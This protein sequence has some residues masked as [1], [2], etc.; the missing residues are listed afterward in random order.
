MIGMKK[1]FLT[2]V[3]V[4]L[5]VGCAWGSICVSPEGD[6]AGD[7]SAQRPFRTLA[8]A[9]AAA[10]KA[11]GGEIRLADGTYEL[12]RPLELT[13]ADAGLVFTAAPGA[14][15][16]V[17]AGRR[18]RNWTV[19]GKG[20]WHAKFPAGAKFS[21]FYVNGQRRTRPFL[22]RKGY[23]FVKAEAAASADGLQQF[24]AREGAFDPAWTDIADIEACVVH[25]WSMS[26][27]PVK[28]YDPKSG[29]VTLAHPFMSTT[30]FTKMA[31]S[32]WYRLDNVRA[33]FGEPGD[34]YLGR[35]GDLAYAP[36]PGEDPLQTECVASCLPCAVKAVGAT[37]VVFRGLVFA[38]ADWTVPAKGHYYAQAAGDLPGAVDV[39]HSRGIRLERCAVLHTGAYA[40]SFGKGAHDC[41]A[42]DCELVDL[43]AGGVKIGCVWEGQNDVRNHGSGCVVENCLIRGGGRV[44]PAGVGVFIAH[45][46]HCR[47][48][49][50]TIHDLYYSGVSLGWNWGY[51][52]TAHDNIIEWNR[53][54]DIGQTVLSDMGGIYALGRQRGSVERFNHISDVRHSRYGAF[55]I[56]FDSGSSL[57]TVTNNVVHDCDG[58]NW[59]LQN[60]SASNVVENNI[61]ACAP[62][63]QLIVSRPL[64][65]ARPTRFARNLVYWEEG[66]FGTAGAGT[67]IVDSASNLYWTAPGASEPK[68]LCGFTKKDPCFVDPAK[69]DFRLH[70]EAAAR[71]VGFVPFSVAESGRRGAA[72]FTA[73][74][75]PVTKVFF[76]APEPPEEP[77]REDFENVAAAATSPCPGWQ[78]VP[79]TSTN[80]F[81]LVEGGAAQGR[82]WLE[83]TD[84]FP[85]WTPHTCAW[86]ARKNGLKTISFWWK[87]GKGACP[88]F[89]VRDRAGW[90]STPG[91][92]VTIGGDRFLRGYRTGPL[93]KVPEDAWF[94]VEIVFEV[95]PARAK[96]V[97][98]IRVTLPG[99]T[100]PRVFPDISISPGFKTVG[101]VGFV[102][103]GAVGSKYGIDD[104]VVSP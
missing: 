14:Q 46:H 17:S 20:R 59:Y 31:P 98:E 44:D 83:V 58:C 39:E 73:R 7:G 3:V 51:S 89:E 66:V 47:A 77:C 81:R 71:S 74:L 13:A 50:N 40:I 23:F 78:F 62:H 45:A 87:L 93:V 36:L 53:I 34:W 68:S 48:A 28:S 76:P 63:D 38:H 84:A 15:P 1:S 65:S 22:P 27:M 100:A 75:P 104:F 102:S 2:S 60:L 21:Q 10:R 6:D 16:V 57:I 99:E 30:S 25:L 85:D 5:T 61:F 64:P 79:E 29:L 42:V 90:C 54:Y 80:C 91:P 103:L 4:S 101:W 26:R 96:P 12:A 43:G 35:D 70:D 11:G 69:R 94:R 67:N 9:Q 32:N 19:D 55:G 86:P 97:Y 56:Y 33:A 49:H 18:V 95:G 52:E 8:R 41:A 82:F 88:E 37:N 92:R 24:I 72:V